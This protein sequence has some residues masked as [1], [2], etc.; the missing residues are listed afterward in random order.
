M[1]TFSYNGTAK[2][3]FVAKTSGAVTSASPAGQI[4]AVAGE[5]GTFHLQYKSPGGILRSDIIKSANVT[6]AKAVK[7]TAM[8][9]G[10][11]KWEVALDATI[12]SGAPVAGQDYLLDFFFYE[13]GSLSYQEQ[14]IKH[15]V[16]RATTG[17]TAA[18]FY[19]ELLKSA[20]L[21][22]SREQ[23]SL[24][25]FSLSDADNTPVFTYDALTKQFT[26]VGTGVVTEA[27]VIAAAPTKLVIEE[28]EQPYVR[29]LKSSDPLKFNILPRNILVSGDELVWGVATKVASTTTVG[30]GK[31]VA[32]M[33]YFYMGE[34]GDVYRNV[35]FPR[36][37]PTEYLADPTAQYHIIELAYFDTM[38]GVDVQ[39]QNK[40]I[41]IV[42]PVGA[43]PNEL[44]V[45]NAII[46]DINT[47]SG[48]SI[49]AL[50]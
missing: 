44:T 24:L 31:E 47:A 14:Y 43:N 49:A 45:A 4:D 10:L 33:E 35:G 15:A 34:R 8:A 22:F 17:M 37:I 11:A 1:A 9:R 41:S 12:N 29:G 18:K 40:H 46:S 48:L 13:Y 27:A 23:V 2:Q 7:N 50:S 30:N 26:Q 36:V 20:V 5:T 28:V 32:D 19:V 6:S 39:K 25:S 42:V 38:D 21:N 16:V 3:L